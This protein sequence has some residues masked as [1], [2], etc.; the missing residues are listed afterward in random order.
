MVFSD[1]IRPPFRRLSQY[2]L[3]TEGRLADVGRVPDVYVQNQA[4]DRRVHELMDEL[5]QTRA[6]AAKATATWDQLRKERDFHKMHHKRVV[7][8]KNKLIGDIKRVKKHYTQYEPV[9][10]ELRSK[11]EVAIK[12]KMLVT[13][14][15]DRLMARI[16]ALEA[17][18]DERR[19]QDAMGGMASMDS[20]VASPK[21]AAG[22]TAGA[23]AK[24]GKTK[25]GLPPTDPPN[26]FANLK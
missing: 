20:E 21:N 25:S 16:D 12:E 5:D 15:R 11:Y 6:L 7:Q 18:L 8:E 22:A 24:A 10:K 26:P 23:T 1:T 2:K 13:L 19:P 3:K 17:E 14:E 4:L 9:I